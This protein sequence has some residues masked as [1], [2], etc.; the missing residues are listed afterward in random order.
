MTRVTRSQTAGIVLVI[1]ALSIVVMIV[2][3]NLFVGRVP[4]QLAVVPL[5]ARDTSV[6]ATIVPTRSHIGAVPTLMPT[7]VSLPTAFA[8]VNPITVSEPFDEGT[9]VAQAF[10]SE[11]LFEPALSLMA[12]AVAVPLEIQIPALNIMAPVLAVGL[13]AENAMAAP[14]GSFADDP[15]WQTVFWYRGG[16]VPG[17]VGTATLAG[18][19]DDTLGRPAVFAFLDDLEVGSLIIVQDKR[20]GQSI[21]FIV[22]GK[23][24]YTQKQS[25]EPATLVRIFGSQSVSGG[26]PQPVTDNLAHLTLITCG[27]AWIHGAFDSRLVVFAIRANYPLA[28]GG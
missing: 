2:L 7:P 25:A 26:E 6:V 5:I 27:G 16:A 22:T 18:H 24:T 20:S 4:L 9:T 10:I 28:V 13:T 17:S 23:E 15:I 14:V 12:E 19:F 11:P 8:S 1:L 3:L 21:P